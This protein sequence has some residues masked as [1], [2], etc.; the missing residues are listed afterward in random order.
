MMDM[1]ATNR[2]LLL[3]CH[4]ARPGVGHVVRAVDGFHHLPATQTLDGVTGP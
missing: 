2:T 4:F 3:A 1:L